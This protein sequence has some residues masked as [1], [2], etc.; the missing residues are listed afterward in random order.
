[1]TGSERSKGFLKPSL[2]NIQPTFYHPIQN[3]AMN[4]ILFFGSTSQKA[5]NIRNES[6][7]A[8]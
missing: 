6:E 2:K 5:K 1:M 3:L 4:D 7:E 8:L